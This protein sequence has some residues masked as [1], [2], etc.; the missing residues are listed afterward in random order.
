MK[1]AHQD[2]TIT[3]NK[4]FFILHYLKVMKRSPI[5]KLHVDCLT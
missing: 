1:A 5:L 3:V 2:H 4:S